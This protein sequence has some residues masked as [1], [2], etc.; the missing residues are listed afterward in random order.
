M[1]IDQITTSLQ[2]AL[3]TAGANYSLPGGS[4]FSD[5]LQLGQILK[6]KV[7]RH[8]EGSRY[9][10]NF[11]GQ[12]KVVDSSVPLRADEIIY[13]RVIALG[14]RVE[15]QRVQTEK[16]ET[17]VAGENNAAPRRAVE[18]AR[19]GKHESLIERLFERYAGKLSAEDKAS[20]LPLVKSAADPESM[21][22]AGLVLSKLG[23]SQSP[24]ILKVVYETLILRQP[25]QGL[26]S[27]PDKAPQ[28]A[29]VQR[30]SD[31]DGKIITGQLA[32]IIASLMSDIPHKERVQNHGSSIGYICDEKPPQKNI[33]ENTSRQDPGGYN[34]RRSS[35][36]MDLSRWVMNAQTEGAVAHRVATLPFWLGDQLIE[37]DV[38]MFDQRP[39][40]NLKDGVKH[41]Q[42]VISLGMEQLGR[43]ELSVKVAGDRLRIRVTTNESSKTEIVSGYMG[44]LRSALT[45]NGWEVDEVV[46][47]TLEELPNVAVPQSVVEHIISQDSLNRLM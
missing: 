33:D 37:V 36:T 39:G 45:D 42:V 2:T 16:A 18:A 40:T 5:S 46:Y 11:D 28:L 8:F 1:S 20:L 19:L 44:Y 31:D 7:L 30:L 14:E 15:L 22:M 43:I 23:L 9:L 35:S 6:G 25:P 24:E 32:P 38:A 27:L 21:V 34:D 10:V 26:F 4:G 12:E 3:K 17:S 29:A 13:G 41:R 47:A